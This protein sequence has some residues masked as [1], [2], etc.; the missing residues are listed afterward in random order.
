LT[1]AG[2]SGKSKVLNAVKSYGKNFCENMGAA[3]TKRT[4]VVTALTGTAAVT[5]GGETA[6]GACSLFK[7]NN[8]IGAEVVE[9]A[10]SY[11]VIVDEVSFAS[12]ETIILLNEKLQVLREN[13]DAKYGGLCIVFAGDFSQLPPVR[14]A[15]IYSVEELHQWHDWV[16]V[17]LQLNGNH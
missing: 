2:G 3:F 4:I 10:D 14:S 13:K 9:W 17:L 16:N 12:K 1:G 5:I 8:N 6:H 11:L 7:A 15:S